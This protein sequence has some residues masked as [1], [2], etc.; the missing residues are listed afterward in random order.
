[1]PFHIHRVVCTHLSSA[2]QDSRHALCNALMCR[3]LSTCFAGT[4]TCVPSFIP[5]VRVARGKSASNSLGSNWRLLV[6]AIEST[7]MQSTSVT[8]QMAISGKSSGGKDD[9]CMAL[10]IGVFFV[11]EDRFIE[12]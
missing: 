3:S 12:R 4:L 1:M 11:V 9:L 2:L 10:L 7:F 6:M 8:K 5:F